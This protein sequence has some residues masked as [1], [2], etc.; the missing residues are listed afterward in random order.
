[1]TKIHRLLPTKHSI[2]STDK[3]TMANGPSIGICAL[4][5]TSNFCITGSNDGYVRVWSNDYSQ[6]YIEAKHD[7][8]I[9]GLTVSH[10]QTR[11]LISTVTGSLGI[12]N[13]VTKEHKNLIRS[14]VQS[15]L[16]VDYD[17][18]RK[19]MIS[20]GQ[21]GT[22]RIWCFQTGKQLSEFTAELETPTIVLYAPD[23]QT[24]ACGFDNGAIK[25]FDLNTST[26]K[27]EIK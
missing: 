21:D 6:V 5:C 14:H 25:V 24:F 20:I 23:R 8:A 12:L 17:D 3:I 22:I 9:R 1:V 4:T 7:Q 26:I 19:Q 18:T 11:I 27:T 10:D 13:L 2:G 15:V 16:G